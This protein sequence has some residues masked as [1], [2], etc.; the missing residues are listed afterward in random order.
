M[1]LKS[2]ISTAH[3]LVG[4]WHAVPEFDGTDECYMRILEDLRYIGV[5]KR[6]PE[7]EKWPWQSMQVWMVLEPDAVLRCSYKRGGAPMIR[8]FFFDGECFMLD[9]T[10]PMLEEEPAL[11]RKLYRCHPTAIEELPAGVEE[12]FARSM[13][14]PWL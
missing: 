11:E 7:S 14:K 3:R 9:V 8:T 1:E 5:F 13:A 4:T 2:S 10:S 6:W 12:E